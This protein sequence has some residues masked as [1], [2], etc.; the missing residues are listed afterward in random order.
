MDALEPGGPPRARFFRKAAKGLKRPGGNLV[1]MDA[2]FNPMTVAHEA[3]LKR[4]LETCPAGEALLLLSHANVDKTVYAASLA[5]RLSMLDHYAEPCPEISVAGCSHARFV[6]KASALRAIYPESTGLFFVVGY[7]TL[8]R[9]FDPRYYV[10][11]SD[12]LSTLFDVAH[13]VA[14][15]RDNV[16]PKAVQMLVNSREYAGFSDRIHFIRLGG[17]HSRVSSTEVRE[18]MFNGAVIGHLVPP[19]IADAIDALNLY[20]A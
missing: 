12:E 17:V 4:A 19:R 18:L 6:D 9:L 16:D 11:M 8:L 14:A 13:I 15:N 2:S 7:D 20:R 1:V 3:M 5:H 10:N